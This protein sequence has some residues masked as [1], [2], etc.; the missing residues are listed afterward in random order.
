MLGYPLTFFVDGPIHR[1]LVS[2]RNQL[3]SLKGRWAGSLA[4]ETR[5]DTHI[6]TAAEAADQITSSTPPPISVTWLQPLVGI[7]ATRRKDTVNELSPSLNDHPELDDD[8]FEDDIGEVQDSCSEFDG[9]EDE[10]LEGSY[11]D[12]IH[13]NSQSEGIQFI[14]ELLVSPDTS[15]TALPFLSPVHRIPRF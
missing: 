11:T 9:D 1:L 10:P 14:W 4:S 12:E 8:I 5:F 6:S 3:L 7:T 15:P 13:D 2:H